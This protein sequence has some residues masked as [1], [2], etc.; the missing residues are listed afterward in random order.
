MLKKIKQQLLL[1][2]KKVMFYVTE[3]EDL[4]I[5]RAAEF[6]RTLVEEDYQF[7][8]QISSVTTFSLSGNSEITFLPKQESTV[9]LDVPGKVD[10]VFENF[11]GYKP[12]VERLAL[13]TQ[14]LTILDQF[15]N[16]KVI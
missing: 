14:D 5:E 16:E 6:R 11:E 13:I 8:I 9:L 4:S 15:S 12:L 1:N 3:N 10:L 7:E 2:P